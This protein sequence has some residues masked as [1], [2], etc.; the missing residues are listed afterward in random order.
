MTH[1]EKNDKD[2]IKAYYDGLEIRLGKTGSNNCQLAKICWVL[3]RR[4]QST[5]KELSADLPQDP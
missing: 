2:S 4:D 1:G 3:K 5:K